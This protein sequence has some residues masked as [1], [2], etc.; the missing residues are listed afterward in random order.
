MPTDTKR[1][2]K[3]PSNYFLN[4]AKTRKTTYEFS[5]KKVKQSD[6]KKILE[7]ARWAPSCSNVQ[8]WQFIVVKNKE[9]ISEL[10]KTAFY[11]AFHTNPP[12][13]IAIVLVNECWKD[14]EHRCDL[15]S[16]LGIYEGFLCIGMSA[17]NMILEAQELGIA[18]ALL[19]P[20]QN[21][22]KTLRGRKGDFIP[23]MV[24]FGYEK[25]KAFQKKRERKELKK[26]VSGEY[27]GRKMKL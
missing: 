4:L 20:H 24:A 27:F 7:A 1:G 22:I 12:I 19:S 9:R 15:D 26:L 25:K 6:I 3:M 14:S 13:I 5:D 16:K 2:R 23:L 11:G 21:I 18:S 10:M 17:L 8:P